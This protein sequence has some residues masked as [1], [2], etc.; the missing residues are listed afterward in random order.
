MISKAIR[1]ATIVGW[2]L[3]LPL[4]LAAQPKILKKADTFYDAFNYREA[5]PLY[6]QYLAESP[7]GSVISTQLK[8]ADAYFKSNQHDKAEVLYAELTQRDRVNT[9]VMFHYAEILMYNGK[10]D[11]AKSWFLRYQEA[12]P[13]DKKVTALIEACDQVRTIPSLFTVTILRP[14]SINT[15]A[16]EFSP[17]FVSNGIA[18]L[19]DQE[20]GRRKSG[21]TG[22]PFLRLYTAQQIEDERF[23]QVEEFSKR[24]ETYNKHTGPV[25]LARDSQTLIIT[26]N[27]DVPGKDE[28]YSL[29]LFEATRKNGH[30]TRG[31]LMPFCDPNRNYMHPSLSYTGDTLYFA[32][33]KGG[34]QGGTDLYLV[35]RKGN[36]WG[37]PLNLGNAINTPGHE[38]FPYIHPDGT[39]YFSSKGHIGFGGFDL[40]V[41][42]RDAQGAFI[43]ARNLGRPL[44]SPKDDTGFIL[45][46]SGRYGFFASQRGGDHD[47]L[48]YFKGW[49]R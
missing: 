33:D 24:I 2:C 26:R 47:D 6:E 48:Y 8:L 35:T 44:N 41:A 31:T 27:S 28:V 14:L 43:G 1:Q 46:P 11:E 16:D 5:I 34:S 36:T 13:N 15:D 7:S 9:N 30:W 3:G 37:K 38:A 39:L 22:R 23:E 32:S 10:Y 25:A 42:E 29:Q 17:I 4:L 20:S 21:W 49:K 18:F 19:S 12:R 40:F 45:A